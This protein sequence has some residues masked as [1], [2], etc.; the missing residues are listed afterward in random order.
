[1]KRLYLIS[2]IICLFTSCLSSYNVKGPTRFVVTVNAIGDDR[3]LHSK[4]YILKGYLESKNDLRFIEFANYVKAIL[5]SKGYTEVNSWNDAD[6]LIDFNYG[7]D[8]DNQVA[9][10]YLRYILLSV[11]DLTADR[12]VVWESIITSLGS[13]NDLRRIVPYMLIAGEPYFGKSSG[14]RR[15]IAIYEGDARVIRLRNNSGQ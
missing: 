12:K 10:N 4:K 5:N 13:S 15:E 7:I 9:Q 3:L 11:K 6:L 14:Q 1:M 2:A 8:P